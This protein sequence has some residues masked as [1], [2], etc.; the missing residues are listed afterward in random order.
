MKKFVVFL[1]ILTS[2]AAIVAIILFFFSFK[3]QEKEGVKQPEKQEQVAAKVNQAQVEITKNSFS[4]ATLKIAKGDIVVWTNKDTSPHQ[5]A[6]DPYPSNDTVPGLLS[7]SLATG[8]S[9]SFAFDNTGTFTYHDNLNPLKL[10][11]TIVVE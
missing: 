10:K 1:I 9:F 3:E 2:A 7:D 6:S 11:G 5:V 8:D 4:P